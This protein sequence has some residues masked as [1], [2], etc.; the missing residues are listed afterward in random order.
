M[1]YVDWLFGLVVLV[2]FSL[3]DSLSFLVE[4]GEPT[5]LLC[6]VVRACVLPDWS[7]WDSVFPLDQL[8]VA[9]ILSPS[10][11]VL[12]L[13]ARGVELF[14][15]WDACGGLSLVVVPYHSV[16][17][18]VVEWVADRIGLAARS[19]EDFSHV[20]SAACAVGCLVEHSTRGC[21]AVVVTRKSCRFSCV[22]AP[23][24]LVGLLGV[25]GRFSD[26][27]V[28]GPTRV[29]SDRAALRLTS[30]RPVLWHLRACPSAR[31]AF[32]L[33]PFPG[34][35]I[36][37]GPLRVVSDPRLVRVPRSLEC[38]GAG[39]LVRS[40]SLAL[41]GSG[42]VSGGQAWDRSPAR[43][44]LVVVVVHASHSDGRRDLDS[45]SSVVLFLFLLSNR[46]ELEVAGARVWTVCVVPLVV[47][48]VG[49]G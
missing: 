18:L 9:P 8:W 26:H 33:L 1:V 10:L 37:V 20:G 5:G 38:R 32:G 30:L 31:C 11:L 24:V 23:A 35:P 44:R 29:G 42:A 19:V 48:S 40:H 3:G 28:V 17:L 49:C 22:V 36:L 13:C 39:Q 16:V 47:S 2:E 15:L 12:G 27:V 43:L 6:F 45:W 7:M 21:V 25:G 14:H 46:F 34:T 41:H 4:V